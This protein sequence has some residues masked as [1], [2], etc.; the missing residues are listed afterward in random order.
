M[1]HKTI[2]SKS[3]PPPRLPAGYYWL[4][5]KKPLQ[6]L[7][8]LLPILLA[9][10]LGMWYYA[11]ASTTGVPR[12]IYARS[13]LRDFFELFDITG[14]Y[15]PGLLVVVVLFTQHILQK[16]PWKI[17]TSTCVWM[18]TECLALALPLF[19]F[20]MVLSKAHLAM[21]LQSPEFAQVHWTE[22]LVH[23]LGAGIY[24]ELLF[25]LIII[26]ILHMVLVD[27]LNLPEKPAN[28]IIIFTSAVLFAMYHFSENNP[29]DWN[30]CL[31]YTGAGV[32]FAGI[33]VVRGF[34]IVA[35]THAVYDVLVV[36]LKLT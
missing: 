5:S 9:Y 1:A 8:F 10:E 19:V 17:R 13:L 3:A 15:L 36:L 32:Y 7:V 6:S 21:A 18:S 20:A 30:K 33:Y 24:E 25:R 2:S 23:S 31:F 4:S 27:G 22:Q 29:F 34:G 14:Y 26:A 35:G 11:S 28:L 12:Y 16:D